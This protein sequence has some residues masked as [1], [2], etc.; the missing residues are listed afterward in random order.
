MELG[1]QAVATRTL[2]VTVDV[3]QW[4]PISSSPRVVLESPK[5]HM[6]SQD[7]CGTVTADSA[8]DIQEVQIRD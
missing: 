8:N 4:H 2:M 5:A 6:S 7:L 1:I 3:V